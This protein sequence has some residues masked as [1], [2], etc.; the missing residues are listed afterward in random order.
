[1]SLPQ[2]AWPWSI[3]EKLFYEF[4]GKGTA[5][6]SIKVETLAKIG[7]LIDAQKASVITEEC[8]EHKNILLPLSQKECHFRNFR[9]D[10]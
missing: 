1:M 2:C 5:K 7:L 10:Y 8:G 3:L 4:F 9:T 6:R